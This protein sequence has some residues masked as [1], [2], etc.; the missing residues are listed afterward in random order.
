[1]MGMLMEVVVVKLDSA[2]RQGMLAQGKVYGTTV[3]TAVGEAKA[4]FGPPQI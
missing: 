1:M 3:R 4:A 2:E